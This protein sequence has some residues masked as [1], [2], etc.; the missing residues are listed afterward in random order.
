MYACLIK[1]DEGTCLAVNVTLPRHNV[2]CL[3][4]VGAYR[5]SR[6]RS[7]CGKARSLAQLNTWLLAPAPAVV[8][9]SAALN[10]SRKGLPAAAGTAPLAAV[11]VAPL[12]L[13]PLLSPSASTRP[14]VHATSRSAHASAFRLIL[15]PGAALTQ[16][17]YFSLLCN[18][19]SGFASVVQ[20]IERTEGLQKNVANEHACIDARYPTCL[21]RMF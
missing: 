19:R 10:A 9:C 21:Q 14:A 11:V 18:Y 2:Q 1:H 15:R 4:N 5:G 20:I 8:F 3:S 17:W 13:V 6:G 16:P 12:S 7:V